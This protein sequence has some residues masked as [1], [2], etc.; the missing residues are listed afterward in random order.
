MAKFEELVELS[1]SPR[2]LGTSETQILQVPRSN[3]C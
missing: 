3:I 2:L 1:N